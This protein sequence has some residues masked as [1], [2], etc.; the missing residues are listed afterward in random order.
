MAKA[1][2]LFVRRKKYPWDNDLK[3][4]AAEMPAHIL[5]EQWFGLIPDLGADPLK[6]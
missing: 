5:S 4:P 3:K 6:G 2:D 1:F